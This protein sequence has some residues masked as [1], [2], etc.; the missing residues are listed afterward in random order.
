[1]GVRRVRAIAL[2][3]NRMAARAVVPDDHLALVDEGF[4]GCLGMGYSKAQKR[5]APQES[6]HQRS[7]N[8]CRYAV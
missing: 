5:N 3:A 6:R 8:P 1:M 4:V 7:P 2:L